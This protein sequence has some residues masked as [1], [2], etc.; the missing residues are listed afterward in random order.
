M[1]SE[2]KS[3]RDKIRYYFRYHLIDKKIV[4]VS[5]IYFHNWWNADT[6]EQ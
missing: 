4:N 2:L 1:K 6:E 3:L 5:K